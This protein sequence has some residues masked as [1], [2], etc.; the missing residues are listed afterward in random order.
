MCGSPTACTCTMTQQPLPTVLCPRAR[1]FCAV[2]VVSDLLRA[3]ARTRLLAEVVRLYPSRI[4]RSV[5]FVAGGLVRPVQGELIEQDH[6][7]LDFALD[8]DASKA[9]CR[10]R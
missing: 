9:G 5:S 10:L 7:L 8:R 1:A 3:Q 2:Y 4:R 6:R